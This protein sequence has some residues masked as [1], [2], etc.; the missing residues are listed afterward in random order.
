MS[1]LP[2]TSV[3]IAEDLDSV[4]TVGPEDSPAAAGTT[5]E[6]VAAV[7][8]SVRDWYRLGSTPAIQVCLRRNGRIVL[9]RAIGHGWGNAPSDP[10]DAERIPATPDTPFCGF[11][12]A[13][14]VASTVMSMLVEQGAFALD[15]PV[16]RYIPEFASHGKDRITIGEVLS[17]SA[18][19]PFMTP[20]YRGTEVVP[21]EELAVAALADL[22]PSWP[23]NRF[24]VY[25]ALTGGLIQRLLVQRATGK[26]MREHLAEQVLVP[27]G[28]RWNNFSV[29]PADLDAVVP[30][31]KTG[32]PPSR[33]AIFLAR[34]ALGGRMDKASK[35]DNAAFL[36]AEL[37]SGNLVTTAYELSRFYE[38]LTHGGELDGI[39]IIEPGT[40]RHA[41]EPADRMPGAAGRVS[42]AGFELGGRRSKFGRDTRFH[43]G[44]SGLT[45]QYGWADPERGLAGAI[46]TSGK[47]S[48]DTKRPVQ[49]VAQISAA[50]PRLDHTPDW[51]R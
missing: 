26:R 4:T 41:I 33:L 7:W 47:A 15:D 5:P 36:T 19:I 23:P 6:V 22:V 49:L 13:K 34:K 27:F 3:I 37:P 18:G 31:V 46:L 2:G 10:P 16:C 28:F 42:R 39:R 45:T 24:R 32:P 14:G 20:P 17:H 51:L 1:A 9:N 8:E 35:A 43:F 48:T 29:D 44:R 38:I 30:S 25:H 21:D 40:L 11:S 12:T 50:L